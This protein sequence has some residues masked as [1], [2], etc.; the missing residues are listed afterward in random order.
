MKLLEKKKGKLENFYIFKLYPTSANCSYDIKPVYLC[1]V[2]CQDIVAPGANRFRIAWLKDIR[3]K[4]TI[5]YYI[6]Q[7][8]EFGIKTKVGKPSSWTSD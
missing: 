6:F 5:F 7:E 1:I 8:I 2:C 3:T 4:Q